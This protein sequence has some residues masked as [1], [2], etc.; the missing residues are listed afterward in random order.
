MVRGLLLTLGIFMG[1]TALV[2]GVLFWILFAPRGPECEE[3]QAFAESASPDGTWVA[4]FYN[5]VCGGGLGTT[6]VFD[7]VEISHSN[8]PLRPL[9]TAGVVFGM[10]D[11]PYDQP[12]PSALKW[13]SAR[14]LEIT[15]PNDASFGRQ[16]TNFSD[17]TIIYKYVPDDPIERACLKRWRSLPTEEMVRRNFSLTENIKAFLAKC[18]ADGGS[19]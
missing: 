8:D 6:S 5:N 7:T 2:F 9:P 3:R 11:H 16:D 4:R 17:V 18:H 19:Q 1:G 15:I 13:L 14:Q 12:K 10:D